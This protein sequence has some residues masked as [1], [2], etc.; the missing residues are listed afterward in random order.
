MSSRSVSTAI[1]PT[2]RA[3]AHAHRARLGTLLA[4]HG[5]HAGQ[6]LL[7]LAVWESPGMRQSVLADRLGVEAPTVTRMVQRLERGGMIERRTD[8][9]DARAV[10]VYPAPRSRLLESTVRRAWSSVDELLVQALGDGDAAKLRRLA[11]AAVIA[12][13]S[14]TAEP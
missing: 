11:A 5:L 1:G 2:L 13:Q 3:L 12:L 10:L 7:L 6:D 8:P 9:H 14:N 4:P